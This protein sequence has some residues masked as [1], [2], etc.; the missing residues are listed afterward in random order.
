MADVKL[1]SIVGG[2]HKAPT[3]LVS[4]Q[5]TVSPTTIFGGTSFALAHIGPVIFSGALTAGVLK[6]LVASSSPGFVKLVTLWVTDATSRDIRLQI[7][8]DGLV[9]YDSSVP[10]IGANRG[11]T[12]VGSVSNSAVFTFE[13]IPYNT[14][15]VSISS[16]LTEN[17][18]LAAMIIYE[19]L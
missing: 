14:I 11:I 17:S 7:E 3:S 10:V 19:V 15:D 13:R 5:V 4:R 9:V 1:S 18:K 2:G 8:L 16:S 12:A 6:S